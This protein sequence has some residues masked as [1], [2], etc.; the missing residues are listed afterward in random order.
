MRVVIGALARQSTPERYGP[1]TCAKT[2]LHQLAISA[3]DSSR[4]VDRS[5]C[6]SHPVH[7]PVEQVAKDRN[8]FQSAIFSLVREGMPGL[9]RGAS[10]RGCKGIGN[11]NAIF[12]T[13][14]KVAS[15]CG[16]GQRRREERR[17]RR[18]DR[19]PAHTNLTHLR[20]MGRL[21]IEPTTLGLYGASSGNGS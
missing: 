18:M 12:G 15:G 16:S 17:T 6:G 2:A 19:K 10:S 21:G 3:S 14:A 20:G 8:Y 7:L 1:V 11:P 9:H 13:S 4:S 5:G